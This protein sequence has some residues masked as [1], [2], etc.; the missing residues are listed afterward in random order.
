MSARKWLLGTSAM[1]FVAIL[2]HGNYKN[3]NAR[4]GQKLTKQ[5]IY[6]EAHRICEE[7]GGWVFEKKECE[8]KLTKANAFPPFSPRPIPEAEWDSQ[9]QAWTCPSSEYERSRYY[10]TKEN[11]ISKQ[12]FDRNT[13]VEACTGRSGKDQYSSGWYWAESLC[14]NDS[15]AF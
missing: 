3:N 8:E 10:C 6:Q 13:R 15:N 9:E 12:E 4:Y 1:A 14:K 2:I 5:E 7:K 11:L